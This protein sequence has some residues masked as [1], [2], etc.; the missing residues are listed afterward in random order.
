MKTL[1]RRQ[2]GDLT[3]YDPDKGLKTIAVAEVAEK[4]YAR[5]KDASK[6]EAAIRLKLTAQAEFVFWPRQDSGT[7][8]GPRSQTT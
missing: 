8:L 1:A 2:T 7:R 6:L 4:H 5:A 3:K